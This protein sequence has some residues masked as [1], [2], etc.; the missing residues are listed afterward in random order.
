MSDHITDQQKKHLE[1]IFN[2]ITEQAQH[3]EVPELTEEGQNICVETNINPADLQVKNIDDFKRRGDPEEV[4]QIRFDHYKQK[5][6]SKYLLFHNFALG[7][8]FKIG[9]VYDKLNRQ[10][11]NEGLGAGRVDNGPGEAI[12]PHTSGNR[13]NLT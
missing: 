12:R 1:K 13:F 6:Y 5:R 2:K 4:A 8:L 10:K 11:L 3:G 7:K 9:E